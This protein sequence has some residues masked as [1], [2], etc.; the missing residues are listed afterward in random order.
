MVSGFGF[1]TFS[2][3]LILF[4]SPQRLGPPLLSSPS[5]STPTRTSAS[6]LSFAAPVSP[7]APSP[8]LRTSQR[9]Q[10]S[11]LV[12]VRDCGADRYPGVCPKAK[13]VGPPLLSSRLLSSKHSTF[14]LFPLIRGVYSE[15]MVS[16]FS[17]LFSRL[18]IV[19]VPRRGVAVIV[20][21]VSIFVLVLSFARR[22]RSLSSLGPT[23]RRKGIRYVSGMIRYFV[24][25]TL[26]SFTAEHVSR[27]ER[28]G[29]GINSSLVG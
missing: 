25:L 15:P 6:L 4:P 3:M 2:H 13:R 26:S 7:F 1:P 21:V 10:W 24:R 8:S 12:V 22:P 20:E 16:L 9:R 11:S 28:L 29:N 5:L 23:T 14:C 19:V 17:P 27:L 18:L